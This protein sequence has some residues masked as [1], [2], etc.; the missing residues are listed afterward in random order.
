VAHV[1][2]LRPAAA[3]SPAAAAMFVSESDQARPPRETLSLLFDLTPAE[4]RIMEL[5]TEGKSRM[6]VAAE[7]SIAPATVKVH[8]R[9]IFRKTSTT[10]QPELV[11]L[12]RGL[13]P[14]A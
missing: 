5:I 8:L 6:A 12:V 10:R 3:L 13:A 14:P 9:S 1:M 2:P 11:H 7:L 4:L